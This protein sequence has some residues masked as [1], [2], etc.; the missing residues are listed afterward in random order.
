VKVLIV[1]PESPTL[2]LGN[3]ITATRWAGILRSLGHEVDIAE[4][5]NGE[6]CD[7]L[8]ALHARRSAESVQRFRLAHARRPLIVALTG[9]DLY[10]DLQSSY[11]AHQS[12]EL[13]TRIVGL[14]E[15]ARDELD[16]SA[17]AKTR[18]IY[19]S[20]APPLRRG[21][22]SNDYF[23]VCVLSHLRD[24]KDPL[25]AAYAARLLP[26]ESRIRITHAG[27]VLQP[28]W[29]EKA[30]AEERANPR[31]RW[32]GEQSHDAAMELLSA[33]RLLVLS[34]KIEGGANAIG[35]AVV[36]GVPVLCSDVAGNIGMLGSDYPGYF[37]LADTARLAGLLRRA[38]VDSGFLT[39]LRTFIHKFQRR[40]APQQE[41]ASWSRL[42][43]EL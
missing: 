14:Q 39:E 23:D 34:S 2:P 8:I 31:Y 42:I 20:A 18:I 40:F 27:R 37:P 4:A 11:S 5:W 13:A 19:Q 41:L 1:T 35:E 28:E 12:L 36:C 7:L 15:A 6:D 30:G 38:E 9:T 17:R 29:E 3:T 22:V 26:A 43:A 16:D 24:V 33:S 21:Q 25:R 32:I 10:R